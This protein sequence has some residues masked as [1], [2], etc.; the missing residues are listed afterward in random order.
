MV[1][2][3]S[4]RYEN[5]VKKY[6]TSPGQ[7]NP[8]DLTFATKFSRGVVAHQLKVKG[9]RPMTYQY[10]MVEMVRTAEENGVFIDQKKFC[11]Q[12]W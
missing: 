5:V 8:S 11:W 10:L 9:S 2:F 7:V 6:K 4:P 3:H 1:T 12:I